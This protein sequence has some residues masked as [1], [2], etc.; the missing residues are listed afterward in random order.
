MVGALKAR[1]G[2][3]LPQYSR[4]PVERLCFHLKGAVEG[5]D[6]ATLCKRVM[7]MKEHG[8]PG[9]PGHNNVSLSLRSLSGPFSERRP[10]RRNALDRFFCRNCLGDL[11][12]VRTSLYL[13]DL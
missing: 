7:E 11:Y 13:N 3:S 2:T 5:V 6:F 1:R 10:V 9:L 12:E 4:F 8:H